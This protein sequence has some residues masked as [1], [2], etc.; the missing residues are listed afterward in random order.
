[1]SGAEGVLIEQGVMGAVIV[2][3]V[4]G[5][6]ALWIYNVKQA[7]AARE[8]LIT[9]QCQMREQWQESLNDLRCRNDA[10]TKIVEEAIKEELEHAKDEVARSRELHTTLTILTDVIREVNNERTGSDNPA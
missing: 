10:L 3:L 9:Q 2:L 4:G 1:M 8:A 7:V 5:I 6:V